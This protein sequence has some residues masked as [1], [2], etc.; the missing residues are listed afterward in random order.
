MAGLEFIGLGQA[1]APTTPMGI[2]HTV[3]HTNFRSKRPYGTRVGTRHYPYGKANMRL[4]SQ[5]ATW[6]QSLSSEET[7]ESSSAEESSEASSAE[8]S[9][10]VS[11][12]EEISESSSA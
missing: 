11:S 1:A 9:S 8:E 6:F 10:E 3:S 5:N 4:V 12:A 7:S 2:F